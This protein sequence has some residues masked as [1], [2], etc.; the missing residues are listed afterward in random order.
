MQFARDAALLGF[1]RA[2]ADRGDPAQLVARHL[3]RPFRA[4]ALLDFAP[5]V[6]VRRAQLRSARGD[7][8]FEPFVRVVQLRAFLDVTQSVPHDHVIVSQNY[9]DHLPATLFG[10]TRV[11]V[12][13]SP[14]PFF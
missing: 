11:A 10:M 4:H 12:R 9:L 2:G 3:Q 13:L 14:R 8:L 5:Q 1:A 6:A 7:A